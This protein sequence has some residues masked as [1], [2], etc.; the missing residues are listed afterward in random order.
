MESEPLYADDRQARVGKQ[1]YLPDTKVEQN[2]GPNSIIPEFVDR[3]SGRELEAVQTFR[4]SIRR[5]ITDDDDDTLSMLGDLS[6][7]FSRSSSSMM[8]PIRPFP[9]SSIISSTGDRIDR[10]SAIRPPADSGICCVTGRPDQGSTPAPVMLAPC[11]LVFS[12]KFRDISLG[13]P[14]WDPPSRWASIES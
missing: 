11:F 3:L 5:R 13:I 6:P 2:L 4:Q 9:I 14:V 1:H 12:E 8:T 10:S 7:W